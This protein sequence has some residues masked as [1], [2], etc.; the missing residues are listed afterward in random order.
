MKNI[1]KIIPNTIASEPLSILS[2]CLDGTWTILND[3]QDV[4]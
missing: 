1:V 2:N 4:L 3:N